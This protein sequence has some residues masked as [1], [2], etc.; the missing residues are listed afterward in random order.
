MRNLYIL[1]LALFLGVSVP[2]Y[3]HEF[4]NSAGYGPVNTNAG[5]VSDRCY[6]TKKTS[7]F[8]L[9]QITRYDLHEKS[10]LYINR[11][12]GILEKNCHSYS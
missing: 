5:W 1:G 8:F 9:L 10:V 6:V 11:R 3:F 2:Q 4:M 12:V 7:F